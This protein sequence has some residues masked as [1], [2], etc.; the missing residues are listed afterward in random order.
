MG[1]SG[2]EIVETDS[3]KLG[4]AQCGGAE[5]VDHVLAPILYSLHRNP[6]SWPFVDEGRK[7][8]IAK[9]DLRFDGPEI[10]LQHSVRFRILEAENKVELLFVEITPTDDFES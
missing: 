10:I 3:Y 2:W 7:I 9:T 8:R 5:H 4:V 6:Q 1:G